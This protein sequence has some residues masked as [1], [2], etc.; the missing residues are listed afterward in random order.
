MLD[1]RTILFIVF[2]LLGVGFLRRGWSGRRVD[3]HPW[4]RACRFDLRGRW[5]GA[6]KCPECGAVLDAV[7]A[8]EIGRRLRRPALL[9]LG[10]L[11]LLGCA[12]WL[13]F[14]VWKAAAPIDWTQYKRDWWV[15]RDARSA[16]TERA[17]AALKELNARI[18]RDAISAARRA[19]LVA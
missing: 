3:N 7:G 13:G 10:R 17:E 18:E 15:A 11:L 16:D 12:V 6:E 19:E 1:L 8:V 2:A 5:P 14:D 9:G 4:C